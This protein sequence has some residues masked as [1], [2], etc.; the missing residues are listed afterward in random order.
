MSTYFPTADEAKFFGIA[1]AGVD[2]K[3]AELT[4]DDSLK[5]QSAA[6]FL[7][8]S[9]TQEG[10]KTIKRDLQ[11]QKGYRLKNNKGIEVGI[12]VAPFR[13]GFCV[14]GIDLGLGAAIRF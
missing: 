8:N 4:E 6:G 10:K 12:V 14:W 1:M 7:S 3:T 5:V 11:G 2:P 9:N 13:D